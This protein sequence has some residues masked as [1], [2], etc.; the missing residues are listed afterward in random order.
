MTAWRDTLRHAFA[1]EK[2]ED[3]DPPPEQ[4]VVAEKICRWIVRRRLTTMAHITLEAH[5]GLNFIGSQ[6][7]HFFKPAVEVLT[8]ARE[9]QHFA[10]FMEHRGSIDWLCRR[11]DELEDAC[12]AHETGKPVDEFR[13]ITGADTVGVTHVFDRSRDRSAEQPTNQASKE[14]DEQEHS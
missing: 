10:E 13:A 4:M 11:M 14:R 7:M 9:Y 12:E 8:E 3:F 6:A 1:V 2:A 5:R